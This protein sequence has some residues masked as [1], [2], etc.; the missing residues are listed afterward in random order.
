MD[1][2]FFDSL[3]KYAQ[4]KLGKDGKKNDFKK[5]LEY[6]SKQ[7][8]DVIKSNEENFV[9]KLNHEY[10]G[11]NKRNYLR[12]KT[13]F[14]KL[15]MLHQISIDAGMEFQKQFLK[16]PEYETDTLLGVLM[17]QHANAC[18]ITGEIIHLLKGGYADAALARWRTL[19]EIAVTCLIL[20]KHGKEAAEDYVKYGHLKSIEEIEEYQKTAQKMRLE[21]YGDDE[22]KHALAI[23]KFL[24]ANDKSYHWAQKHTKYGKF[25]KLRDYVGLGKWSHK[26]MLA[27]KN[28]HA[29]YYEMFSFLAMSEAKT[30]MLLIGQSNSGMTMPAHMTAISLSQ[31]TSA[32]L[33]AYINDENTKLNYIS[34]IFSLSLIKQYSDEV[35]EEFLKCANIKENEHVDECK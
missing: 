7:F 31:I 17:Q 35:G 28:I 34:S 23:K 14:Q 12:W 29:N 27:S 5:A 10:D 20:N 8:I 2:D 25:E 22:I 32:F 13:A 19:F 24:T 26:Y 18:R 21:P 30:D 15:Q 6:A 3:L 4:K 1:D 11:F 16:Y 9:H 33:T